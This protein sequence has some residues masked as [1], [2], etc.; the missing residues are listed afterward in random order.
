M[1]D[2]SSTAKYLWLRIVLCWNWVWISGNEP[3]YSVIS[4]LLT[5]KPEYD[6]ENWRQCKISPRTEVCFYVLF[7]LDTATYSMATNH[8]CYK[9]R[10]IGAPHVSRGVEAVVW[11]APLH[12]DVLWMQ[13]AIYISVS[14]PPI[15]V[16]EWTASKEAL[17]F[18]F[19]LANTREELWCGFC[20]QLDAWSSSEQSL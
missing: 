12:A 18:A 7:A 17:F 16:V 8:C 10:H 3:A 14:G 5:E 4:F 2:D 19:I 20:S 15:I 11:A 9:W 1:H 6:Q 13:C